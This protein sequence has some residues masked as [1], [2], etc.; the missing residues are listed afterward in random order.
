MGYTKQ[1][2]I[3][4][5]SQTFLKLASGALSL[6]K[7]FVL[8]RLLA[9]YDFG[10]F[11]LVAI[12]LG[13]TESITQTGIN[14]TILQS[15]RSIKDFL[16]TAW[17]IAIIR[18][19]AIG[20]I[21][22]VSA[23]GLSKVYREPNLLALVSLAALIPIIKGFINPNI[24]ALQKNLEYFREAKYFL[25]LKVVEVMLAIGLG[26]LTH[27]ALALVGALIGT[28]I[29]EVALSFIIFSDRPRFKYESTIGRIIF[30]NARGLTLTAT[31]HYA[32]DNIDD[33]IIGKTL[34]TSTLGLYHNAYTLAHEPNYQL[35]KSAFHSTLPILTKFTNDQSRF[36]RGFFRAIGV[37]LILTFLTTTPLFFFSD[38]LVNLLLGDQWLTIIPV[39]PWLALAGWVQSLAGVAYSGLIAVKQY[40]IANLH[41]FFTIFTMIPAVW[42]LSLNFGLLGAG[43]GILLSRLLPLPIIIYGLVKLKNQ[44]Q[45]E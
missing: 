34:G 36:N 35:S 40:K 23:F 22:V 4:F 17:V 27:S 16:N 14:V 18:G 37:M 3:G 38:F 41:L 19:V 45:T 13:L 15:Q 21:M 32:N 39:L 42:W 25:S 11:S 2:M 30:N 31:L 6:G 28:A 43:W 9:P 10:L 24:T 5:G 12:A 44:K 20:L 26:I 33:I 8:A 7:I 1:A 29:F